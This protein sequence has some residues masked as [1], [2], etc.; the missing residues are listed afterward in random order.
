MTTHTRSI[1]VSYLA[2]TFMLAGCILNTTP[3][4]AATICTFSTDLTIGSESNAVKCLQQYLNAGGFTVSESGVGSVGHETTQFKAKTHA[5]VKLW[6]KANGITPM[7]G[8]FGA[9]SRAKYL[10]LTTK[11]SV[12]TTTPTPT[13]APVPTPAPT[14]TT[15]SGDVKAAR[16]AISKAR[17]SFRNT[18]NDYE[19]AH[20][21][22]DS[23]GQAKTYLA[24]VQSKL[25]DALYAFVDGD[26]GMALDASKS[27]QNFINNAS[28]EMDGKSGN[29]D[30]N[31][32]KDAISKVRIEVNS[33]QDKVNKADGKGT[34]T[35]RADSYL[36][37]A[38]KA[39]SDA[40][41]SYKSEDYNDAISY[42]DDAKVYI[43]DALDAI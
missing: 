5:A 27:A 29:G 1:P 3:A 37:K 12:P 30:R 11:V 35:A 9:K 22:G 38:R 6:Q 14:P 16:A 36:A 40:Q 18:Q 42:I 8:T 26:Y 32:A 24:D 31:D 25:M 41:D 10:E 34:K 7:T 19:D 21:S 2:V 17:D 43:S 4:H 23:T 33:A 15:E 39:I 20:D 13:P 28:D